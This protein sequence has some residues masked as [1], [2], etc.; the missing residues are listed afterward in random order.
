VIQ[1]D[2]ASRG[3]WSGTYESSRRVWLDQVIDLVK[4]RVKKVRDFVEQLEPFLRDHVEY[5]PAAVEKHLGTAG[6]ADHVEALGDAFASLASFDVAT[7]ETALRQVA[8]RRGV[9]AGTLIHATRVALT[10]QAVSPGLFEVAAL[11]GQ[12]GTVERLG[13]LE[14]FLRA[15]GA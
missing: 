6:L 14:R 1:G 5:D 3:L 13:Q 15:R 11:V 4:P 8:E 12:A 7:I 2:L 10:G 9:K